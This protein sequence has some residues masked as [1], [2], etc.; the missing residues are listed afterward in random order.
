LRKSLKIFAPL[1]LAAC[2]SSAFA[3]DSSVTLYGVLDAAVV[4]VDH[5]RNSADSFPATVDN[6]DVYANAASP[7]SLARLTTIAN[8]GLSYSRWGIKGN[9]DLGGG[10]NAFFVLE[11]GFNL[12]TGQ[13]NNTAATE[14]QGSNTVNM[15][16]ADS[17]L[18]GQLFNRAANFG[19][20]DSSMGSLAI[21]RNYAPGFDVIVQNDPQK[22]SPL[23][24]P[25]GFSG[26][27]G[28]AL[29]ATEMIRND[30]SLRYDN[31]I[32]GVIVRGI[33]KFGNVA[34][35]NSAGRGLGLSLGYEN[36]TFDVQFAYQSYKDVVIFAG[37][38]YTATNPQGVK[39]TLY[40][41]AGWVV[42][43]KY[44]VLDNLT[45]KAGYENFKRKDPT[46]TAAQIVG[47]TELG[48]SFSTSIGN[49]A[50]YTGSD[51]NYKVYWFGG[52]YGITPTTNLALG[53]YEV[54]LDAFAAAAGDA[55]G[56]N[57]TNQKFFSLVLDHNLSKRTDVY[58]GL[59]HESIS[60]GAYNATATESF[61]GSTTIGLGMRHRF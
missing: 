45:L 1:A 2:V 8:S 32:D 52:D 25:L 22:G 27:V 36:S 53:L 34:G 24:S 46:D 50:T 19:L 56:T 4:S 16:N 44:K 29:G 7:N 17:S 40:D 10:L 26:T 31:N 55:V 23:F 6:Y 21:G 18:S 37:T 47:I 14:A 28:G 5:A 42:A 61:E 15:I 3:D 43:G 12:P 20:K 51:K 33:V 11:S 57:D 59:A 60:G 54:K 48:Y 39:G 49:L 30:N 9:E 58:V 41:T 38:T 35:N 13:L